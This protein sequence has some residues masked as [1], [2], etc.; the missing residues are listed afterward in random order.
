MKRWIK[1]LSGL[2]FFAVA[3]VVA[4]FAFLTSIY[5]NE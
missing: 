5:F 1:I 2:A 3:V 4:G